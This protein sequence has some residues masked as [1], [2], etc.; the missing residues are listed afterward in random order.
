M[1]SEIVRKSILASEPTT[2]DGNHKKSQKDA[3]C[4]VD[5]FIHNMP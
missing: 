3:W 1:K 5:K 4:V 2:Y